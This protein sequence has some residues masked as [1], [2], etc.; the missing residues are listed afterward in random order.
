[1]YFLFGILLLFVG[2]FSTLTYLHLLR[3]SYIWI[4]FNH[5]NLSFLITLFLCL[6][7]LLFTFS[8]YWFEN[9]HFLSIFLTYILNESS[10]KW[11]FLFSSRIQNHLIVIIQ[12]PFLPYILFLSS[13]LSSTFISKI[14]YC[15]YYCHIEKMVL[16]LNNCISMCLPHILSSIFFLPELGSLEVISSVCHW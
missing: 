12:S 7:Y 11:I 10:I 3:Y 16:D 5:L 6:L 14:N 1:M 8:L 2:R 9:T 13:I 15:F 4:Y